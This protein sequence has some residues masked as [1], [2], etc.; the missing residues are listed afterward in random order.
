METTHKSD[1]NSDRE[2]ASKLK[3][4]R[5]LIVFFAIISVSIP[6]MSMY[7]TNNQ[8]TYN[9]TMIGYNTDNISTSALLFNQDTLLNQIHHLFHNENMTKFQVSIPHKCNYYNALL[10]ILFM[11]V[12]AN[13]IYGQVAFR[14]I[15]LFDDTNI[16]VGLLAA[17]IIAIVSDIFVFAVTYFTMSNYAY[18]NYYSITGT[19]HSSSIVDTAT[20]LTAFYHQSS[21]IS[22]FCN[23]KNYLSNEP[24]YW[25]E[26]NSIYTINTSFYL[27]LV[28][29]KVL[30]ICMLICAYFMLQR[31]YRKMLRS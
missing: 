24:Y 16:S 30:A 18:S 9:G 11:I 10:G 20:Q 6:I 21:F 26:V 22:D 4:F 5:V 14:M 25:L 13:L 15:P 2:M 27:I 3:K 1:H 12:M 19:T 29:N 7:S 8:A 17:H 28:L 23:L 31:E